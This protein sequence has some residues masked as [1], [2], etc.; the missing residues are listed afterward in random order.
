MT[1]HTSSLSDWLGDS[2]P[3]TFS[4]RHL[5]AEDS[6]LPKLLKEVDFDSLD[7]FTDAVVPP[8]I[9]RETELSTPE[10]SSEEEAL[11]DLRL[12]MQQ[13]QTPS[14]YWGQGYHPTRLPPTLLRNLLEN[15]GWYTPYT[16]YQ[17]EIAQGRLE[18]L[19]NF[20]TLISDLTGLPFANASLLDEATACGEA[21]GLAFA[22]S[23]QKRTVAVADSGLHPQNLEVLRTRARFIGVDLQVQD[24]FQS[25]LPENCC[26]V[27]VQTP[28]THGLL[29]KGLQELAEQTHTAGALLIAVVDPIAQCLLDTP[30]SWG[31]DIAVGSTQRFGLPMGAGGP[32]AG[33][34]AVSDPLKRRLPGRIVG[35]S[36]D[37]RGHHAYRLALQTREQHIRRDKATSNICTAQ[38]LPAV[39][40]TAYA[41]YHGPAGLKRIAERIARMTQALRAALEAAGLDLLA[42]PSFDTLQV[43]LTTEEQASLLAKAEAAGILLRPFASGAVGIS[44]HEDMEPRDLEALLN[45]FDASLPAAAPGNPLDTLTPWLRT[46]TLLPQEVFHLYHT[47]HEMLRYL[48]RLQSKDVSLVHSMIS[49]GSCTM[50]LNAA[51]EMIPVTWPEVGG[52]HP[53]SPAHQQTG[54]DHLRADLEAWLSDITALPVCSLQPNA[55]SQGE[56]AGLLA[57]RDYHVAR[58]DADRDICLIPASAHGTN[59]ASAV[60]AGFRVVAVACD[61]RGN[62]DSAD[63]EKKIGLHPG[64]IAALMMTYPS[65]HGVF[66][67]TVKEV[68]DRIHE[69]GGQV[70]MDGAN[71]NAQVGLTAPGLIGADVCHLN[72]HKTFC[73]PHGGGGPGMGP[74]C[75]GAHL[76]PHMPSNPL[77]AS[78]PPLAISATPLGSASILVI[79]WMYI[80]MMGPDGLKRATQLALLNA[81]Y[82][83]KKLSWAY[84]V[85]YT[86]EGGRVAH[87]FILDLRDLT[88]KAGLIIDD[89][90]KRLMDYGFHAP[91]MSFPVPGTLMIEPTESESPAELDRFCEAMIAIRGEIQAVI[92]GEITPE[93]SPLHHAPHTA[94]DI[95]GEWDR[96]YSRELAAF[97][98]EWVRERKVWPAANRIDNT[99]GDRNLICT[100]EWNPDV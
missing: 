94:A 61:D 59:P 18:M 52:V 100:C 8:F 91:T 14:C 81:N 92:D 25:E 71:M 86:G 27:L 76:G 45:L 1:S 57:I 28:D 44:L 96:P 29:Q 83:A 21:L 42:G 90:A 77:Q 26:A 41:L 2:L 31:A 5:G 66:E 6:D 32:H 58:G 30:A 56:L 67:V 7:A 88:S 19:L 78:T 35:V 17:A 11:R 68:C 47:E 75:A 24:V 4:S 53:A 13:N 70:Y 51:A 95:A 85:L 55:G 87:E 39:I 34:M 22:Q 63:L 9:R 3:P 15:P 72:L 62:I 23:R 98:L 74:I 93:D 37:S 84:P 89:I 99:Y 12:I 48:N 82:M 97:P 65:T 36:K 64:K 50:K 54:Y 80:R 10:G 69:A 43:Q 40:A 16:P 73:I 20:Q 38:V 46:A 33:F 79:S 49:L 60:M